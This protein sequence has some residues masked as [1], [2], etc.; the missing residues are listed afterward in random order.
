MHFQVALK[1]SDPAVPKYPIN[2]SST[3]LAQAKPAASRYKVLKYYP[4]AF[5]EYL[6]EVINRLLTMLAIA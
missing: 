2:I 4:I 3:T 1:L 5:K 6:K